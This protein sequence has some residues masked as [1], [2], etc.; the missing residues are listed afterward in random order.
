MEN[1]EAL[2][3]SFMKIYGLSLDEARRAY[4]NKDVRSYLLAVM[5]NR[6]SDYQKKSPRRA[7]RE[8]GIHPV[9]DI[10]VVAGKMFQ[11]LGKWMIK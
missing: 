7:G 11:E 5:E 3:Y 8:S 1:K 9:D 6:A 10:E 4:I 2:I